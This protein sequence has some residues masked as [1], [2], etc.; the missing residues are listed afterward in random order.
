MTSSTRSL[1]WFRGKLSFPLTEMLL[2]LV[3]IFWGSSYGIT[4]SALVFSSV[5]MFMA[6]RFLLTFALL[7]FPMVRDFRA[8]RNADWKVAI[9]SGVIL[10]AIFCCEIVGISKTTA[11]NAAFL[12]SLSVILTAFMEVVVNRKRLDRYY[13]LLSV[14]SVMGVYLLTYSGQLTLA[15]NQ[16][17]WLI[18]AAA[19]LRALMVT[20]TKQLTLSKQI[21]TLSLTS[22]QSMVVGLGAILLLITQTDFKVSDIPTDISFWWMTIYL[23]AFCTLFAFF[24]QNYAVRKI[25]PTKVSLLMGSE[26]VFG[27][28]FAYLWLDEAMNLI[29]FTGAIAI[30]CSVYLASIRSA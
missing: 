4:K 19:L 22:L 27:A 24:V 11:T 26:P 13:L 29:Q 23:V 7:I 25:S 2:L 15:L 3:A 18:L 1:T 20:M 6:I 28:L 14:F 10:F 30:L 16:G 8:N 9:P 5:F 17:D 12:I 21:T